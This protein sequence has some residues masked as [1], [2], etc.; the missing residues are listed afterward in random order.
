[1]TEMQRG[2]CALHGDFKHECLECWYV[3][4]TRMRTALELIAEIIIIQ[5]VNR[6]GIYS[7]AMNALKG[8]PYG[9]E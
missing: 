4:N 5:G 9:K 1:M 2:G 8:V 7:L 6:E 3:E